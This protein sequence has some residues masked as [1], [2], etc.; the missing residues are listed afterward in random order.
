[1]TSPGGGDALGVER[2]VVTPDTT[3]FRAQ[4]EAQVA[5]A[6]A[7]VQGQIK[8]AKV[9]S[10]EAARRARSL[11]LDAAAGHAGGRHGAEATGRRERAGGGGAEGS[12]RRRRRDRGA[13]EPGRRRDGA[14]RRRQHE[15]RGG[16]A[17]ADARH[18]QRRDEPR[19]ADARLGRGRRRLVGDLPGDLVRVGRVPRRRRRRRRGGGGLE[20]FSESAKVAATTAQLIES[21]GG[22]ANLTADQVER[23]ATAQEHLTGIDNE[24]IQS[25]QNVLLTF[26]GI[27]DEVGAGNQVFTRATKARSGHL[28]GARNEPALERDPGREGAAGPDQGDHRA[29]PLRHLVHAGPAQ[30]DHDAAET[31]RTLEAQKLILAGVEQQVGGTAEAIGRTLPGRLNILKESAR[32]SLGDYVKRLQESEDASKAAAGGGGG[33]SLCLRRGQGVALARSARNSSDIGEGLGRAT[34]RRRRPA[35]DDRASSPATRRSRSPSAAQRVQALYA[36]ATATA[37]QRE[38]RAEAVASNEVTR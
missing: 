18:P 29:A 24:L 4:L 21:T 3:A 9:T 5:A 22:A 37:A 25:G 1:V 28:D 34:E 16:D 10:A 12:R 32:D 15:R 11:D 31:G 33:A 30:D 19:A 27:R 26:R 6:L 36:A 2:I 8:A 17:A 20:E 14:A 23:L 35:D 13:G 7:S 38:P